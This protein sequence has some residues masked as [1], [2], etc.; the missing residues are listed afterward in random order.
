MHSSRIARAL[1]AVT[2]MAVAPAAVAEGVLQLYESALATNPTLRGRAFGVDQAVA[3][4]DMARSRLL[5]QLS[6]IGSYDANSYT[7]FGIEGSDHYAG[8]RGSLIGR[9]ALLDVASY[10]R[11]KG[12]Q[13]S[14]TQSEQERQAA[15]LALAAEVIDRYLLVLQAEDDI[16]FLHAEKEAIESQLKRLRF[17]R[18]KQMVKVTDLY[19]VEAYYQGLLT[20]EIEV[21]NARAIGLERLRETTGVAVNHVFPLVR[22]TLP[23]V[24][25]TETQWVTDSVSGNPSLLALNSAIEAARRMIDSG[26]AEHLPTVALAA[27]NTYSDQ[28]YDNRPVPAYRVGTVGVEVTIPIFEGG[29]VR[30]SVREAT[31]KYEIAREQYEAARREIEGKVR[32]AYLSAQA[33]NARIGSTAE[34]VRALERVVEAQQRS[35]EVGVTTV[36]DVLIARRRLTKSRSDHAKARYDYVRDL[37]VLR[38]QSGA[39]NRMH[40]EEIDSWLAR[41]RP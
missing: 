9:Q 22:E 40:I 8:K 4:K 11:F 20:R 10:H 1:L 27:S 30:A 16:V 26:N 32:S 3:Q 13:S 29:R 41:S 23:P 25:G 34:E 19:E 21:N 36:L 2:F 6:A 31:A 39:L 37:T 17:M 12:A 7:E 28:G 14:V 5:P 24:P 33:S 35:F 15:E 18:E 38:V